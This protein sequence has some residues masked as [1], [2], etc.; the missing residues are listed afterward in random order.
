MLAG[1]ERRPT[2]RSACAASVINDLPPN[3][4]PTCLVF[5]SLALFPHK[6]VGENIDFPLKMRGVRAGRAARPAPG[7]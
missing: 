7:R 1:L 2:A 5:Q 4:R 6:T 3:R